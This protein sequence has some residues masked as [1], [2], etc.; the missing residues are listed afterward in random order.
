MY[1]QKLSGNKKNEGVIKDELKD[2]IS[3][4]MSKKLFE[5]IKNSVKT[6]GNKEEIFKQLWDEINKNEI[7]N[8]NQEIVEEQIQHM[9][10][11]KSDS[12]PLRNYLCACLDR[13]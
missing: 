12:F 4:K 9:F 13:L 10:A 8:N 6:G 5:K 11:S 2:E 7:K 3:F 1:K